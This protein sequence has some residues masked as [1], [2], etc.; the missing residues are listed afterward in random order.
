[1]FRTLWRY[2][3]R[4]AWPRRV[5]ILTGG[6]LWFSAAAGIIVGLF[7]PHFA[8]DTK[9]GDALTIVLAYAAIA[10]GFSVA[11]LTVALTL[12]DA[13][14]VRDLATREPE[15][16]KLRSLPRKPNAYSD[17][18]FVYSWTAILHWLV[19]VTSFVLIIGFGFDHRLGGSGISDLTRATDGLLVFVLSYAVVQ[20]LITVVTLSQVGHHYILKLKSRGRPDRSG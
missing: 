5:E 14:F 19:I 20:F 17:L 7:A 6:E 15:G 3:S 12:P 1:M 16:A 4:E 18:L 9:L 11:G 13:E 10:F 2:V 8:S